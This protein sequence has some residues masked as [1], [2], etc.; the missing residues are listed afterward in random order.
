MSFHKDLTGKIFGRLI[1]VE[2]AQRSLTGILRWK[3]ICECGNE[4][5]VQGGSLK[6]GHT[7]SCGCYMREITAN[8][9]RDSKKVWSP[10]KDTENTYLIPL[11]SNKFAIIDQEDYS[12]VKDYSWFFMNTGY[13][14]SHFGSKCLLMHRVIIQAPSKTY[15]DHISMDRLDNRKCNLR[16]VSFSDNVVNSQIRKCNS[17]GFKGVTYDKQTGRWRATCIRKGV[18]FR[19]RRYIT[20]EEAALQYD[21]I[22]RKIDG[23]FARLNFPMEDELSCR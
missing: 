2:E 22:V 14:G 13:A 8:I 7:K 20:P 5:I 3:C 12:R 10:I 18:T 11:S 17:S 23:N 9:G 19:L 21:N 4:V 1:V 15:V 6:N 16:I